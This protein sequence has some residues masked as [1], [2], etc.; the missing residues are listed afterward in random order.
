MVGHVYACSTLPSL[1]LACRQSVAAHLVRPMLALVNAEAS[2]RQAS[3]QSCVRLLSL[4][5][6]RGRATFRYIHCAC[7]SPGWRACVHAALAVL[8]LEVEVGETPS[9]PGSRRLFALTLPYI[10][11]HSPMGPYPCTSSTPSYL[12]LP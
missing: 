6:E 8:R 5:C 9:P 4:A 12:L 7:L 2:A 11:T 10:R 3:T 1:A